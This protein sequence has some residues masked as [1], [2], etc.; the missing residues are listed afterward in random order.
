MKH[1]V[2]SYCA[3]AA[4]ALL[5]SSAAAAAGQSN[6]HLGQPASKSVT[7][8]GVG[9]SSVCSD[10]GF[11]AQS[12]KRNLPDA[13]AVYPFVIPASQVLVVT[14]MD[15]QWNNGSPGTR[16]TLRLFVVN[17]AAPFDAHPEF[18]S[19]VELDAN[20]DGGKSEAA[21]AGF[22]VAPAATICVDSNRSGGVL[23][24]LLLRGYLAPNK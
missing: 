22:V 19:S 5:G 13:G 3:L 7:L 14:D 16:Q 2:R 20:G 1:H 4:F 21:T 18:E 24:H 10:Q 23:N 8:E 9:A 15:W 17:T 11:F 12:F 6:T